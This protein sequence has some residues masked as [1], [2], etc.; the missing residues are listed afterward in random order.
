LNSPSIYEQFDILYS[1]YIFGS[2]GIFGSL[3]FRGSKDFVKIY[4]VE[5]LSQIQTILC[6]AFKIFFG[7]FGRILGHFG[8]RGSEYFAEIYIV[9]FPF[10]IRLI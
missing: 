2:F 9:E 3:G 8:V 4:I 7:S 1:K 10:I 6:V 5:F